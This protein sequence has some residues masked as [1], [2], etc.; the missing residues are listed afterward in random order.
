MERRVF[1]RRKFL[2]AAG[3]SALSLIDSRRSLSG[4]SALHTREGKTQIQFNLKEK[5]LYTVTTPMLASGE[6]IPKAIEYQK[7]TKYITKKPDWSED[8]L[9]TNREPVTRITT[10]QPLIGLTID[11]GFFARDKILNIAIAKEITFTDFMKGEVRQLYPEYIKRM[12]DSQRVEFG[13]H[14]QVHRD[15]RNSPVAGVPPTRELLTEDI[16]APE[17]YLNTFGQTVL[18]Y[19]RP[20]GGDTSPWTLDVASSLGLRTINWAASADAGTTTNVRSLR[21]G[22]IVLM[23]YRDDTAA[24]F[25]GWINEVRAQGLE[26]TA[27]SNLFAAEGNH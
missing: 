15:E 6:L 12:I 10:N 21:P 26:P 1:S 22:D 3:I 27:L 2:G 17:R 8:F 25:A 7:E 11:D 5:E 23:H 16:M 19:H 13:T 24:Q 20:P 4:H 18:P 14:T 9:R